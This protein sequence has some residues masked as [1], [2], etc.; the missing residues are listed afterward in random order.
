M[1]NRSGRYK[2]CG[3]IMVRARKTGCSLEL[4]DERLEGERRGGGREP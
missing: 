4:V 2:N 3:K 1:Q